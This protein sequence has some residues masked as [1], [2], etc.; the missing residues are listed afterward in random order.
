M[1]DADRRILRALK[2]NGRASA[3]ELADAANLSASACHRRMKLMEESGVISGYTAVLSGEALGYSHEF[4]VQIALNSQSEAAL[5]AFETALG[6]AEE[7]VECHL[8]TGEF[9]YLLRIV[10]RGPSDYERIHRQV[11]AK[12][13][14]VQRM[15]S[16]LT[17]R[18]V[19]A[20]NGYPA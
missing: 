13:P 18:T 6:R 17:L 3:A 15:Q 19:R 2:V 10:T 8:L 12:L 14:Y 16:M 7:I 1:D 20:W 11:L 4:F 9:D 5:D